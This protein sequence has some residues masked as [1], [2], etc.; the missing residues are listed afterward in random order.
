MNLFLTITY[1]TAFFLVSAVGMWL[2]LKGNK[3]LSSAD[4]HVVARGCDTIAK[5][6]LTIAVN[7]TILFVVLL[8]S[9]IFHWV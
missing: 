7:N 6:C 5:G 3:D 9:A 2:C 4:P 1:Y 8:L